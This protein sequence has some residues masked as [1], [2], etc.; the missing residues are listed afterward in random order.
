MLVWVNKSDLEQLRKDLGVL[1]QLFN[2]NLIL[3]HILLAKA[4]IF[5][6]FPLIPHNLNKKRVK[7]ILP[8]IL[9]Y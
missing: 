7:K 2:K 1:E 4:R 5:Q 6:V 3:L 9:T 8:Y